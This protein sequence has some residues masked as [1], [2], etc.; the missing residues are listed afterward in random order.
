MIR[1]LPILG[2]FL[3]ALAAFA[4]LTDTEIVSQLTQRLHAVAPEAEIA[5]N[6]A[7]LT[8]G[9]RTMTFKVHGR[10][11]TGEVAKEAHDEVGPAHDGLLLRA[12]LQPKGEV[13]QAVTPQTLNEPYWRSD[14]DV[15]H[16]AGSSRQLYW[17][18]SYGS[19]TDTNLLAQLR[20]AVRASATGPVLP[21]KVQP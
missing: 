3:V 9:L 21:R 11:M 13:N 17:S 8:A 14:L 1:R 5:T 7:T 6:G 19:R 12:A 2:T 18:L 10:S 4:D 15:T 20:A 16:V